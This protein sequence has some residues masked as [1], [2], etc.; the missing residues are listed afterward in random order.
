MKPSFNPQIRGR[1]GAGPEMFTLEE[2]KGGS[3]WGAGTLAGPTGARKPSD[4]ELAQAEYQV[5][6]SCFTFLFWALCGG[7]LAA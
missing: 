5:R 3:P 7:L 2:A 1:Y 6:R 4:V